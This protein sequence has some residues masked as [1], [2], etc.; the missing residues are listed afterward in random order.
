MLN[1]I[2][3]HKLII[4]TTILAIAFVT[5]LVYAVTEHYRAESERETRIKMSAKLIIAQAPRVF[6]RGPITGA[7]GDVK[8]GDAYLIVRHHQTGNL[9]KCHFVASYAKE[10]SRFATEYK[11]RGGFE[12]KEKVLILGVSLG[13]V[14][15]YR[16]M[17][18]CQ[19]MF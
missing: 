15:G 4:I 2:L 19:I 3:S 14:D 11:A 8:A 10:F 12:N 6:L 9:Y 1:K 17:V 18:M 13:E 5:T 7:I 16:N